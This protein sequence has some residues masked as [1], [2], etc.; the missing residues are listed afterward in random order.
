MKYMPAEY[1]SQI[2]NFNLRWTFRVKPEDEL[3]TVNVAVRLNLRDGTEEAAH[4]GAHAE[5]FDEALVGCLMRNF[6]WESAWKW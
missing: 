6:E 2:K 3:A 5:R 4:A 1:L